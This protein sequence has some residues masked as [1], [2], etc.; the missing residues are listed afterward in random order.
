MTVS[1]PPFPLRSAA[2]R[3]LSVIFAAFALFVALPVA[4][5]DGSRYVRL[6]LR[7]KGTPRRFLSANDPMYAAA[8]AHLTSRA[9]E[10]RAKSLRADR[11]VSTDDLPINPPYLSAITAAGATVAQTSRWLNTVMVRADSLTIERLRGLPFVASVDVVRAIGPSAPAPFGKLAIAP[12]SSHATNSA[13]ALE[14]LSDHYGLSD[15]QNRFSGIDEA[16]RMGIAGEGVLVGVL[17][18]GFERRHRAFAHTRIEKEF[19]FVYN[20]TST[21]DEAEDSLA[22]SPQ[23]EHGTMVLSLI[24]A[25]WRD[26]LVGGAPRATFMLAKTEDLRFERNVEEDNFVAGLEWLE[27]QGVDITNTSLGYTGFD[28]PERSH[29]YEDLTGHDVPA[30]RAV[31]RAT[32]LGVVCIVAAGNEGRGP[33]IYVGVPGEA[34]SA[35][36]AAA[37]DSLGRVAGFSS[38]GFPDHIPSKPDVAAFGV[39]NW[40][41]HPSTLTA[42]RKSQ[43]T[44]FAAPMTTAVATLLLSAAP[45]L[46]PWELRDLLKRSALRNFTDPDTAIGSGMVYVPLALRLLARQRVVVGV[47]EISVDEDGRQL[48]IAAAVLDGRTSVADSLFDSYIVADVWYGDSTRGATTLSDPQPREGIA[49]WT[50]ATDGPITAPVRIRVRDARS[51]AVLRDTRIDSLGSDD[52]WSTSTLC[53]V[54]RLAVLDDG[55]VD[56]YPNPFTAMTRVYF[57][58]DDDATISLTIFNSRGEE[59]V[60]LLEGTS[61]EAGSHSVQ[62]DARGLPSGAYYARLSVGDETRSG[63]M[64]YLP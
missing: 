30:S 31:N 49:R 59:M 43:G 4:A 53:A 55:G 42:T 56:V 57:E 45:E 37:V 10:R 13:S 48:A 27:A 6:Q 33:W 18:A 25:T 1:K 62:F 7:D 60:R 34:D 26:T 16:H 38:R 51:G 64:I 63:E 14:C 28:A 2:L 32:E 9:L 52:P 40:A 50:L 22:P 29:T 61:F 11:M 23:E 8:T 35:I 21:A 41:A 15:F 44:S 20:N 12:P 5:Q 39:G 54:P 24:G 58:L 46:R 36:A 19:D 3:L 47:P 17:D